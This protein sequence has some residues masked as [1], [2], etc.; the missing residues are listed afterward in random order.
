MKKNYKYMALDFI[1]AVRDNTNDESLRRS[2]GAVIDVIL[3]QVNL[4]DYLIYQKE[5]YKK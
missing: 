4:L 5:F 3:N 1:K 2:C